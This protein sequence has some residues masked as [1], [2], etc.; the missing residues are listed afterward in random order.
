M[1]YSH[2]NA[3]SLQRPAELLS[4][5]R[6]IAVGGFLWTYL[7]IYVITASFKDFPARH[8]NCTA[9]KTNL[10]EQNNVVLLRED[11]DKQM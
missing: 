7:S 2:H 9:D 1:F 3:Q 4:R 6:D 8:Q 11:E 5:R 10:A